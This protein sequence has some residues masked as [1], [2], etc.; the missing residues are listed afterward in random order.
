LQ[1]IAMANP[2]EVGWFLGHVRVSACLFSFAIAMTLTSLSPAE[3]S[4]TRGGEP[5]QASDDAQNLLFFGPLRP[6]WIRLRVTI[7]GKPFRESWQVNIQRLFGDADTDGDGVVRAAAKAEGEKQAPA[8]S[9]ASLAA[10]AAVYL[11]QDVPQARSGLEKMAAERGGSLT[12]A[13]FEEYFKQAAPPFSI[14]VGLGRTSAGQ[15][16]FGLLDANGDQQLT[17]EE[18]NAA[19]ERLRI[20]DFDDNE[21]L[22]RLELVDAPNT[23]LAAISQAVDESRSTVLPM[24][25][26]VAM[27]DAAAPPEAIRDAIL[28]EYDRN[29]DGK[30]FTS[31]A[32]AEIMLTAA[33]VAR[34]G[35]TAGEP[36]DGTALARFCTGSP[37][38]ELKIEL[39][40]ISLTSRRFGA[41]RARAEAEAG[42]R[43]KQRPDGSLDVTLDDAHLYLR[44]NNRDPSKNNDSGPSLQ[45]FDADNNGYL[46]DK[47]LA[48][49][50]NLAGA[51]EAIDT[52]HD[53]KIFAGEL[54][55]YLDQQNRAASVRL[56]LEVFDQGQ[57]L[58]DH[59][60]ENHD[61]RLSTREL[62]N[63]AEIVK[64]ID[65]NHDG[66]LSADE[67]PQ[68]L[69]LELS[70]NTPGAAVTE[71]R[72]I[73][74]GERVRA[75]TK[76]GPAWFQKM[77]RNDDGELSP[78]EFLGPADV[79]KRLD[80]DK[81]G[82]LDSAEA[83]K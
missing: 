15:A 20:R 14:A 77:D 51:F 72:S 43:I 83:E 52:D 74:G 69:V 19:E 34:L 50:P 46:D 82:V 1:E 29:Q 73:R 8:D 75:A 65:A 12:L 30:I 23:S 2:A 40:K 37:D 38:V 55:S 22:T 45:T 81:N 62:H 18:L 27:V 3:E 64:Q 13:A 25:G 36:F 68:Q 76:R 32:S 39:G 59:L 58:F 42:P 48:N 49:V 16:L 67:I 57:E 21:S 80:K 60:D 33:Q 4:A 56:L 41:P 26:P 78:R 17:A 28:A 7:D 5:I 53:G 10:A 66:R 9:I 70:R 71:R 24:A 79:F 47:E 11:G 44:R 35:L 61:Y 6:V 63:A 31:G 54:Q